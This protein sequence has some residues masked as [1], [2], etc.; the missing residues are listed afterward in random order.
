MACQ[1][2]AYRNIGTVRMTPFY[3]IL[4]GAESAKTL[5][6]ICHYLLF[7]LH[8]TIQ[9]EASPNYGNDNIKYIQLKTN[10]SG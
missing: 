3:R 2:G 1:I 4:L 5:W 10:Y 8:D 9:K 6:L 7:C